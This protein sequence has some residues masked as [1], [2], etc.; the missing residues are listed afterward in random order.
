[1]SASYATVLSVVKYSLL[2]PTL[3]SQMAWIKKRQWKWQAK[4]CLRYPN[5]LPSNHF[6]FSSQ[7]PNDKKGIW[8]IEYA[9]EVHVFDASRTYG[10]SEA[11]PHI[12]KTLTMTINPFDQTVKYDITHD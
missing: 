12:Q 2:T 1:M 11:I 3:T 7:T 6:D 4:L 10:G 8:T 5:S 9:S